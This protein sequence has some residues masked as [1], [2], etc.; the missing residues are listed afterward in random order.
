MLK[1]LAYAYRLQTLKVIIRY[2][3][4]ETPDLEWFWDVVNYLLRQKKNLTIEITFDLSYDSKTRKNIV[5]ALRTENTTTVSLSVRDISMGDYWHGSKI[6]FNSER[7][8]SEQ[9]GVAV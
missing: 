5:Q 3:K 7:L 6:C 1:L 4:Y 9:S 2:E 8:K